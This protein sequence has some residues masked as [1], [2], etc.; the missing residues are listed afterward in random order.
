[1]GSA[2]DQRGTLSPRGGL[3][4]RRPL[5][6]LKGWEVHACDFQVGEGLQAL[7]A[8]LHR[9]DVRAPES[10]AG[11]A[12]QMAGKP[13]DMLLNVAGTMAPPEVDSLETSNKDVLT[14]T[15]ETNTL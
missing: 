8:R 12:A 7:Q 14:T 1:M 2:S 6:G 11:L 4:P 5:T 15:F 3:R 13:V 9:I 10:I